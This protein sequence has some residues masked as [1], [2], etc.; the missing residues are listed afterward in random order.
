VNYDYS[1]SGKIKLG[2]GRLYVLSLANA[3]SASST[4]LQA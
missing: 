3:Q 2:S 1:C 4:L